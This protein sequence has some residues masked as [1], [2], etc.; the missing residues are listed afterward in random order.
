MVKTPDLPEPRIRMIDDL[1]VISSE[2]V[3]LHNAA[4]RVEPG[5]PLNL[6]GEERSLTLLPGATPLRES[7][8]TLALVFDGQVVTIRLANPLL[9][10][11][12]LEA[13]GVVDFNELPPALRDL[14]HLRAIDAD[15]DRFE[16]WA[17]IP[18]HVAE[19]GS[20][21][22]AALILS[23][24]LGGLRGDLAMPRDAVDRIAEVIESLPRRSRDL[25]EVPFAL[26]L[27]A[28]R[29]LLSLAEA[30][31]LRSGDVVLIESGPDLA[32]GLIEFRAGGRLHVA[33]CQGN[34]LILESIMS[35]SSE[36]EEAVDGELPANPSDIPVEL[37]FEVGRRQITLAELND[38]QTG[39]T[40]ELDRPVEESLVIVR[41]NGRAIARGEL[42]RIGD[43]IGVRLT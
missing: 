35:L 3:R 32:S 33:Q 27:E 2:E 36:I 1:P 40:L 43:A 28:G 19:S 20:P 37:V 11:G 42:V 39:T 26:G 41:A 6:A 7:V 18:I 17:G 12:A 5:L 4:A 24:D 30:T 23:F 8:A 14:F 22:D 34:H 21:S 31:R 9:D 13:L 38:L 25:S 29:T 15:L 16:R 10:E